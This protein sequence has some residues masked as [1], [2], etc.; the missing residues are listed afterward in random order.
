MIIW[1]GKGYLVAVV[2]FLLLVAAEYGSEALFAD[3]SYYQTHGWPLA[4]ALL[5][6]GI[7][8]WFAGSYLHRA[9]GRAVI[10]KA[11]GREMII[12]GDDA[13]FFIPVRFW[14]PI[15]AAGAIAA[16]AYRGI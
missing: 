1:N 8:A 6:S 16:L 9:G 3:Q 2:T 12:G 11:T 7:I 4:A 10:D 15:L 14:G 13:L 5:V